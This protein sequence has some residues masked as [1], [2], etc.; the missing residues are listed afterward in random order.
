V[1]KLELPEVETIRRDLERE[2]I[3]RK[4]KAVDVHGP[5]SAPRHES[6]DSVSEPVVG[7]KV[8]AV[9]RHGLLIAL[10]FDNDQVLAVDLGQ[11]GLLL[12]ALPADLPEGTLQVT[13]S[14]SQAGDIHLTDPDG[15]AEVF[16][17][18]A[19][20]FA[21]FLDAKG[22]AGLDLLEEPLTWVDFGRLVMGKAMPLKL[23][24]TDPNIFAGI[25]DVYSDE[26]LFDAGLRYDRPSNKLSTQEIRRLYR[27]LVGT[28]HDAIKYRGT[29]LADGRYLDLDGKP[30]EYGIQLAV[31]GKAGELSPRSRLPIL[32]ATY[33]GHKVFY[34]A[35]QV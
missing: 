5:G 15:S 21:E 7:A 1:T 25:G 11:K 34:C 31:Y 13:L 24:L 2:V 20:A 28:L 22:P 3:G 18:G 4:V 35:T 23:L 29:T 19:D 27:S 30:G 14:F 9:E 16:V 6:I 26:I 10:R 33:K 8:T 32:K 17:M 12:R